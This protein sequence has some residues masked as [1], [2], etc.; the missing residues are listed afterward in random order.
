ML[1]LGLEGE[2][3]KTEEELTEPKAVQRSPEMWYD[4][5]WESIPRGSW[6]RRTRSCGQSRLQAENTALQAQVAQQGA[7]LAAALERLA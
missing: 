1:V 4:G 7:E 6:R 5:A 3:Q 2:R